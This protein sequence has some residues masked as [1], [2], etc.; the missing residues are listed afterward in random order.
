[1]K[2]EGFR[3][4]AA[5][6]KSL[7][8]HVYWTKRK[9]K[10]ECK[11]LGFLEENVFF[12]FWLAALSFLSLFFFISLETLIPFLQNSLF[13]SRQFTFKYFNIYFSKKKREII[14]TT[15]HAVTSHNS[16]YS[17]GE[18][19]KDDWCINGNNS[20]WYGSSTS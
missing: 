12:L 7:A 3:V 16:C 18:T 8:L 11:I 2:S 5:K 13:P 15:Q 6:K 14:G 4:L 20:T 17:S 1:L 19:L 9:K 10:K